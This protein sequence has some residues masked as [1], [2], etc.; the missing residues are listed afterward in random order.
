MPRTAYSS[1]HFFKDNN[2][3]TSQR[4]NPMAKGVILG[5]EP[6]RWTHQG[7]CLPSRSE[8][9]HNFSPIGF[10]NCSEPISLDLPNIPLEY[11][12]FIILL[13]YPIY[14]VWGQAG[15]CLVYFIG[16]LTSKSC[17]KT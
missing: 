1:T 10:S 17:N 8:R 14:Q 13:L 3:R 4:A 5:I 6:A 2:R 15:R 12:S 9:L 11:G 7:T 16:W